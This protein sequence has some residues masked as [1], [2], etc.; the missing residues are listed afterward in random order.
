M[1]SDLLHRTIPIP[2]LITSIDK[3]SI[4][5]NKK[6]SPSSVAHNLES[7]P[8]WVS[9]PTVSEKINTPEPSAIKHHQLFLIRWNPVRFVMA[10]NETF[11]TVKYP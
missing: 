5:P 4:R 9:E 7:C 10:K 6:T 8:I 1:D 2:S 3:P 11:S